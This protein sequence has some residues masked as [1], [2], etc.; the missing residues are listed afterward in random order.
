[1]LDRAETQAAN[2]DRAA[3][4]ARDERP[5]AP[6]LHQ[7][8]QLIARPGA[9]ATLV[10]QPGWEDVLARSIEVQSQQTARFAEQ[11]GYTAPNVD[12]AATRAADALLRGYEQ[13]I[14]EAERKI[15]SFYFSL[16]TQNQDPRGMMLDGE[17]TL[18]VSG[19]YAATGLVD[20]Y[21]LMARSTWV[22]TQAELDRLLPPRGGLTRRI[23]RIIR[24]AL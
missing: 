10:R 17:T 13:A 18:L 19:F 6:Q 12:T 15:V 7:K 8:T 11:L 1:V 2:D 21:Y 23:A 22:T 4:I 5:R 24:P 20:L 9:I 16:G 14:P 3:T